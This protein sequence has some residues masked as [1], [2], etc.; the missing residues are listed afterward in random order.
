MSWHSPS[1]CGLL[2]CEV[3]KPVGRCT[4]SKHR[5]RC[6]HSAVILPF[7]DAFALSLRFEVRTLFLKMACKVLNSLHC[8]I[9]RR[10]NLKMRQDFDLTL[11]DLDGSDLAKEL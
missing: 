2:A 7:H 4:H 9:G 3:R 5:A 1:R 6:K 10:K 11:L 8:S